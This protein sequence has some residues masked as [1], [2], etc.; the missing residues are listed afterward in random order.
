MRLNR[1]E[2][3]ASSLRFQS[4][5]PR[6]VRHL[7]TPFPLLSTL[8]QSTHPRRVR[9][10][11]GYYGGVTGAISIHAP[12]KGATYINMKCQTNNIL[13]QSTHPRR[14]RRKQGLWNWEGANISI[15]APAKGATDAIKSCGLNENISIHAPAKGA[16]EMTALTWTSLSDFNPRTREGCD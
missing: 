1:Q 10:E 9:Q 8:F 15:H 5:H 2:S 14:V 16:T 7:Q 11:D 4:T 3:R 13:F 6:R 12:A